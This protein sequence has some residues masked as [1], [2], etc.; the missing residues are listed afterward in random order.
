MQARRHTLANALR[1]AA[2]VYEDDANTSSRIPNHQRIEQTFRD[3]ANQAKALADEIEN[4]E[5]IRLSD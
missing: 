1:V 4:A 5:N 2:K 3:Q